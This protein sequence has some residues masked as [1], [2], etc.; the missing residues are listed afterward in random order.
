[1]TLR[2]PLRCSFQFLIIP[3]VTLSN[4]LL[5]MLGRGDTPGAGRESDPVESS[6]D[7]RPIQTSGIS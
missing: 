5:K 6:G 3:P 4:I 2:R 1:M 7:G